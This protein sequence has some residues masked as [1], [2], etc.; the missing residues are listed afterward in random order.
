MSRRLWALQIRLTVIV[1]LLL[2]VAQGALG[3]GTRYCN[4]WNVV[5]RLLDQP[6]AAGAS[7]LENQVGIWGEGLAIVLLAAAAARGILVLLRRWRL[8]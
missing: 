8:M 2:V 1:L 4:A 5:Q 6:T 3:V 7:Y